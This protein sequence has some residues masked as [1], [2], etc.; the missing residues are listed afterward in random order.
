MTRNYIPSAAAEEKFSKRNLIIGSTYAF[1]Q[2]DFVESCFRVVGCTFDHFEGNE[3]LF[4]EKIN[5]V[6][7]K[8]NNGH[9][10][11]VKRAK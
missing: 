1:E 4:P 11:I 9:N 5:I 7:E 10:S 2:F 8:C 3:F 6:K